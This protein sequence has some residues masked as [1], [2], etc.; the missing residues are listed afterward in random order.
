[1]PTISANQVAQGAT[2][3]LTL[4]ESGQLSGPLIELGRSTELH[5]AVELAEAES[6]SG[7]KGSNTSSSGG[8]PAAA[9]IIG[10][11]LVVI[12]VGAGYWTYATWWRPR[13]S[14]NPCDLKA[15]Q[16]DAAAPVLRLQDE[17]P[18]PPERP[19]GA[20]QFEEFQNTLAKNVAVVTSTH[21]ASKAFHRA[22]SHGRA[23]HHTNDGSEAD[24]LALESEQVEE[25]KPRSASREKA[26]KIG[27]LF[28][29]WVWKKPREQ[30]FYTRGPG[31]KRRFFI[32]TPDGNV[33]YFEKQAGAKE[34][35]DLMNPDRVD[36]R[37]DK[38]KD[39]AQ[40]NVV[41]AKVLQLN[42]KGETPAKIAP[43]PLQLV[44]DDTEVRMSFETNEEREAFV[45]EV[46]SLNPHAKVWPS[47]T[48]RTNPSSLIEG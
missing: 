9:V 10:V 32:L 23:S 2:W 26:S 16:P 21:H 11:L 25:L 31:W 28:A 19:R 37:T 6:S 33:S 13:G 3:D 24:E 44:C 43:C 27:G 41:A 40:L 47:R 48:L 36:K 14:A 8:S 17:P 22:S 39:K 5:G 7:T 1:M 45:D 15:T 42:Y 4:D 35:E 29:G 38:S 18:R 34:V 12:L 30:H 20:T 46:T